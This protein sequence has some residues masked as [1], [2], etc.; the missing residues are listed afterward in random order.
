MGDGG[1]TVW[2]AGGAYPGGLQGSV[3]KRRRPRPINHHAST[4]AAAYWGP[5]RSAPDLWLRL[6]A[7]PALGPGATIGIL[8]KGVPRLSCLRPKTWLCQQARTTHL[9]QQ[10]IQD[11]H[12]GTSLMRRTT[13]D[14]LRSGLA[15]QAREGAE[16][17]RQGKPREAPRDVS[18]DDRG[19]AGTRRAPARAA[20]FFPLWC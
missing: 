19:Q 18:H 20:S 15:R 3:G 7:K 2:V 11:P 1:I 10:G 9:H 14:L 13:Q 16:R 12:E 17:S 6:E 5:W 8:G 4:R